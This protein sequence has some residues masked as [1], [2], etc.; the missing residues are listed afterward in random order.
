MI[1][2]FEVSDTYVAFSWNSLSDD[3]YYSGACPPNP[4]HA[5]PLPRHHVTRAAD[6]RRQSEVKS[7]ATLPRT[8]PALLPRT[9]DPDFFSPSS[10]SRRG[11]AE[12]GSPRPRLSLPP[13]NGG[14][15]VT[16]ASGAVE[17]DAAGGGHEERGL[18]RPP[19]RGVP[20]PLPPAAAAATAPPAGR[21]SPRM[22]DGSASPLLLPPLVP[23]TPSNPANTT[24]VVGCGA[25]L[26]GAGAA[27]ERKEDVPVP[28]TEGSAA[29]PAP[30]TTTATTSTRGAHGDGDV[31]VNDRVLH[32]QPAPAAARGGPNCGL[33]LPVDDS[34]RAGRDYGPGIPITR[35]SSWSALGDGGG[36]VVSAG[37]AVAAAG[38][39]G[40]GPGGQPAATEREGAPA[41]A[42]LRP[43]LP[44]TVERERRRPE[45]D[46]SDAGSQTSPAAGR[47]A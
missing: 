46:V 43:A 33:T 5:L 37:S 29:P 40:R 6:F 36:A 17:D 44:L 28:P 24:A 21:G 18:G 41:K 39:D 27:P 2:V 16:T 4:H 10:A 8:S 15:G 26:G 32:E 7:P 19:G 45:E 47:K 20:K 11:C 1:C 14:I 13:A 12:V 9:P 35:V 25:G 42:S 34:G 31:G 23:T 3:D 22:E 38:A 30:T